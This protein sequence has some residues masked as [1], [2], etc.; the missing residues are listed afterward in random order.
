MKEILTKDFIKKI[1][2]QLQQRE[3]KALPETIAFNLL[4]AIAPFLVVLAQLAAYFSIQL[5]FVDR[6]LE[7]YLQSEELIRYFEDFIHHV[8]Q[9]Q[10]NFFIIL[11]TSIPF[12]WSISKG[13]YGIARAANTTYQVP[14]AK[15][16]ILERLLSFVIVCATI[17][18]VILLMAFSI[19]GGR[20]LDLALELYAWPPEHLQEVIHTIGGLLSLAT[21]VLFFL[22]LFFFAP[23]MKMKLKEVVPGALVTALGWTLSSMA[24]SYYVNRI[25]NY[26]IYGS[27]AVIIVL[28]L[29]LYIL[30]YVITLG[31]Q[32]N[33]ILKRDYFGGLHYHSRLGLGNHSKL[34]TKLTEFKDLPPEPAKDLPDL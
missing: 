4:M 11:V 18:V 34:V 21:N 8:G 15:F 12:F 23:S 31:L 10:R 20:I 1:I 14:L 29:W 25:A 30:G 9:P 22:L 26:S 17:V 19:F 5:D 16:A 33:F 27:L 28:L 2:H 32:V 6:L 13:L 7:T 24:F 3:I